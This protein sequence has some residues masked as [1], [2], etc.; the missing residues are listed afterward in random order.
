MIVG[1]VFVQTTFLWRFKNQSYFF[2]KTNIKLVMQHEM[3]DD[4]KKEKDGCLA[5]P[6]S[7]YMLM[8]AKLTLLCPLHK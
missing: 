5:P 6:C 3:E 8:P 1:S 4:Q 2:D 7:W